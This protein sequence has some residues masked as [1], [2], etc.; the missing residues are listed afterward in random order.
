MVY[1]KQQR[2][3]W[4]PKSQL[5][6]LQIILF[7]FPFVHCHLSE[8]W[9]NFNKYLLTTHAAGIFAQQ[10]YNVGDG[11]LLGINGPLRASLLSGH[12]QSP[13][14]YKVFDNG[15]IDCIS[16]ELQCDNEER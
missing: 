6:V 13:I 16:R 15:V 8:P 11:L 2:I 9:T 5:D 10:P 1:K 3:G 12:V 7:C 4:R 14:G